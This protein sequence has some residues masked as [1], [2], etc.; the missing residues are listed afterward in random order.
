MSSP[1]CSLVLFLFMYPLTQKA[2]VHL[3]QNSFSGKLLSHLKSHLLWLPFPLWLGERMQGCSLGPSSLCSADGFQLGHL[4]FVCLVPASCLAPLFTA[5]WW[6]HV[7]SD[8]L[9]FSSH[10]CSHFQ[11]LPM[12][13]GTTLF[14]FYLE[15]I[16]CY[17]RQF[18]KVCAS[19]KS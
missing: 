17:K 15:L 14:F 5:V 3:F 19:H 2:L 4:S 6:G 11:S 13:G 10:S 16:H 12:Q 8:T 1:D 9:S 7:C 18:C